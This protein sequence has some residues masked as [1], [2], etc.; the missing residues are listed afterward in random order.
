MDTFIP[1]ST[2]RPRRPCVDCGW[3]A[4]GHDTNGRCGDCAIAH[5]EHMSEAFPS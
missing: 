5:A 2:L 1:T 3:V 4:R